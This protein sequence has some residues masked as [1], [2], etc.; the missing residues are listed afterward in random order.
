VRVKA[1]IRLVLR[2]LAGRIA[3]MLAFAAVFLLT[4]ITV[5]L[6]TDTGDGHAELDRLFAFGGPTLASAFLVLGWLVGRFPVIVTL[7]LMAGFFSQDRTDGTARLYLARPVSP[8]ALYAMRFATLAALAFLL[9]AL[10]LPAF[11]LLLLGEWAGAGS[12]ALILTDIMV[13]GGLVVLLS[14]FTRADAWIALLLGVLAMTWHALRTAGFL[15]PLMP[16]GREVITFL[17]PPYGA[18]FAIESAFGALRPVPWS[19]VAFACAWGGAL[20]AV[21]A[22]ILSRREV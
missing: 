16:A 19:A 10:L 18:L 2:A 17:L 4:A 12:F 20:L 8:V 9:S 14:L 13:Y 1:S 6:L 11:D 7:V 3:W 21:S 5:R 15:D 22:V